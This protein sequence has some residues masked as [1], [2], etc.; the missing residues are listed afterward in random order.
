MKSLVL[1][2]VLIAAGSAYAQQPPKL[3]E[4]LL[5]ASLEDHLKDADSAKF[6]DLR[7]K[8]SAASG[9]WVMCGYVNSKNS[10]G[11]Y[12]GY[13]RFAGMVARESGK[14]AYIILRVDGDGVADEYCTSKGL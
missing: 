4:R 6:K 9:M 3:N 1:A 7:Y 12:P 10:Y 11:A 8:S 2:L 13:V 14:T 5:K